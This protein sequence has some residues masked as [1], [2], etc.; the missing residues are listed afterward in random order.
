MAETNYAFIKDGNVT[1]VAV[2]DEPTEELLNQFKTEFGLDHIIPATEKTAV[3][4]TW[5]GTKFILAKPFPS[6]ILN[7]AGDWEAPI[8]IP[9]TEGKFYIWNEDAVLWDEFDFSAP[10]Q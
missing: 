3:G 6:W 4:G 2:F 1:N 8:A 7:E 5:D 10:P 9:V